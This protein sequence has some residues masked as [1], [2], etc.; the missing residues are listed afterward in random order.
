MLQVKNLTK[1]FHTQDGEVRAVDNVSFEIPQG[2]FFTLLGPS[3]CGKTTTLRCVAGLE[4]QDAGEIF[5]GGEEVSCPQKN[6]FIPPNKRDIGMVF[7]SYAIW[8]H[9]NVFNNVAFPLVEKGM[10]KEQISYKVKEILNLVKLN[11]LEERPAP[12]LSGGQQQRLALARALVKSPQLM[13][14]DEPLSNLDARLRQIMRVELK[15]LLQE[16]NISSLYVTHDQIEALAMSDSVAV[17]STGTILQIGSPSS[18]Y[19]RPENEFVAEFMGTANFLKGEALADAHPGTLG[20]VKTD[21]G[22]WQS[23]LPQGVREGD[24][25]LVCIRPENFTMA[26]GKHLLEGNILVGEV[27]LATFLGETYDC[28]IKAGDDELRVRVH[29]SLAPRQNEKVFLGVNPELC[30]ILK[31]D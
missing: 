12:L 10:K 26:R 29:H 4:K 8:P 21:H 9:M 18:I 13:L 24:Q 1:V 5:I 14:L 19:H 30:S 16:L 28:L 7:Q 27:E 22:V 25:V 20:K 15:Q 23:P 3:G 11:G 2:E 31:L 17:M 6:L